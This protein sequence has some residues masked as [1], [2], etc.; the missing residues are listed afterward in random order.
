LIGRGHGR[1][2]ASREN[3]S[4]IFHGK[5]PEAALPQ[6]KQRITKLRRERKGA[7]AATMRKSLEMA[8]PLPPLFRNGSHCYKP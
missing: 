5:S 1:H 2:G 8:P 3:Q 4:E 6:P 7:K